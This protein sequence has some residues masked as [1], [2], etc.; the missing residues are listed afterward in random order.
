MTHSQSESSM[1]IYLYVSDHHHPRPPDTHDTPTNR[2]HLALH[3]AHHSGPTPAY[4]PPSRAAALPTKIATWS[5]FRKPPLCRRRVIGSGCSASS[6]LSTPTLSC[7]NSATNWVHACR[8]NSTPTYHFSESIRCRTC[9]STK[10]HPRPPTSPS[11]TIR[12]KSSSS[13]PFLRFHSLEPRRCSR[14]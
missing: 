14:K 3:D 6:S 1:F 11:S 2:G 7:S 9:T 12:A 13:G 5:S 8:T 10:A 4:V